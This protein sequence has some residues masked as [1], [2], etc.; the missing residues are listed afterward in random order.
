MFTPIQDYLMFIDRLND[1]FTY[2]I[3]CIQFNM[4]AVFTSDNKQQLIKQSGFFL[5]E[6]MSREII[7][8]SYVKFVGKLL[9]N[10]KTAGP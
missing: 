2:T 3:C 9:Q 1:P 8:R 6:L 10:R 7:Y 4:H 5:S